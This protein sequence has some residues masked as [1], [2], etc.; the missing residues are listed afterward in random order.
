[1][2]LRGAGFGGP[3][4]E[5]AR[6]GSA[7]PLL[8]LVAQGSTGA[9]FEV[10]TSNV[11]PPSVASGVIRLGN[12][13]TGDE[14]DTDGP[15]VPLEKL[16]PPLVEVE[17]SAAL[18]EQ[19]QNLGVFARRLTPEERV[20]RERF[21]PF[22]DQVPRKTDLR[23]RDYE[24]VDARVSK[25]SAV[26]AVAEWQ[27][28]FLKPDSAQSRVPDIAAALIRAYE[29]YRDTNNTPD[30]I[31]FRNWLESRGGDSSITPALGFVQEVGQLFRR[32]EMMGLTRA[33]LEVAK[34]QILFRVLQDAPSMR[35]GFLRRV[36]DAGTT[37]ASTP[38]VRT[39]ARSAGTEAIDPARSRS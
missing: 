7:S 4:I 37:N 17:L 28:Q 5:P 9:T 20:A 15:A 21:L 36:I 14:D 25:E 16:S 10:A 30:P 27:R 34:A 12:D 24:V 26:Q 8:S 33:E 11:V 3:T 22:Y 18:R 19:L 39:P 35:A 23:D 13:I 1:L 2:N 32:L 38:A 31:G 6:F 29:A